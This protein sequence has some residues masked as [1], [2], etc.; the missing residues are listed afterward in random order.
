MP[1]SRSTGNIFEPAFGRYAA[2][3]KGFRDGKT[4]T[5]S[6]GNTGTPV[7]WAWDLYDPSTGQPITD[8]A[9]PGTVARFD[10][11]SSQTLGYGQDGRPSKGRVWM[12][13]L[14]RA[15]GQDFPDDYSD[16]E[17]AAMVLSVQGAWV[18]L[19]VAPNPVRGKRYGKP[20]VPESGIEPMQQPAAVAP[21]T[22]QAPAFPPATAAAPAAPA[23]PAFGATA[24]A[25]PA[26]VFPGTGTGAAAPAIPPMPG[27]PPQ[28]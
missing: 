7:L 27:F 17:L 25:P 1:F 23:V 15:V 12:T 13:A 16:E 26:P 8:P 28:Q 14:R 11:M 24:A 19:T 5:Y 21:P 4:T 18:F 9:K 10:S 6:D 2:Q 3:F 22:V 20:V